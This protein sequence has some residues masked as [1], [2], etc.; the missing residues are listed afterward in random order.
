[1]RRHNKPFQV[2]GSQRK[3][4]VNQVA[5]GFPGFARESVGKRILAA[6]RYEW[7]AVC[8]P[9]NVANAGRSR[10][11]PACPDWILF[12]GLPLNQAE[13]SRLEPIG[14]T[15]FQQFAALRYNPF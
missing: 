2:L 1:V 5:P 11:R 15:Q 4:Q 3:C 9:I 14:L 13:N 6:F 12:G 7:R 10:I 8:G